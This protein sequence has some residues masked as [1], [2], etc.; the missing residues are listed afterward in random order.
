M[1]VTAFVCIGVLVEARCAQ[2]ADF[3][4]IGQMEPKQPLPVYLQGATTPFKATTEADPNGRFHFRKLLLGTYVLMV[5]GLQQTV[6]VGPSLAD[7]KGRVNINISLPDAE[8]RFERGAR[9]SVRQLS[10]PKDAWREYD[11]AQKALGRREVPGAV[12]HLKQ[13]LALA[14]QFSAAWNHLG[15]IAYQTGHYVEAEADFRKGLEADPDAYA[16]L[17]NLG[18][19]LVN[20]GKWDEAL[21]CNRRAVRMRPNDA[22]ANSQLGMAYFYLGKLDSAEK[23][24]TAAKQIDPGH[25]SHPQMLLAE[26]HLHRNESEAAAGELRDLL[27][28]HP[29]LPNASQIKEEITRLERVP[30]DGY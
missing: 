16:P 17:L 15:T 22:L 10:I 9:I 14:P 8:P 21:E 24:L 2:A 26:I 23:Y 20:L 6:E 4:L 3:E 18:G 28:R 27:A 7:S 25:F 1:A 12:A 19:V 29:D 5:G 13:A 30:R 11:D